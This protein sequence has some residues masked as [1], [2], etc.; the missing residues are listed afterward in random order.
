MTHK[1]VVDCT[2]TL[3][4]HKNVVFIDISESQSDSTGNNRRVLVVYLN[5]IILQIASPF[6]SIKPFQRQGKCYSSKTDQ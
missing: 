5:Q 2:E 4:H 3:Q 1:I 6:S